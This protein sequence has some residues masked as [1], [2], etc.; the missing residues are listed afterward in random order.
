MYC[1]YIL[2]A[3]GA[4]IGLFFALRN[5]SEKVK[6]IV[7]LSIAFANLAQH[8]FKPFIYPH[9]WGN[10]SPHLSSAYNVCAF[11]ILVTPFVLLFG[12]ELL[13]NYMTYLG[14]IAGMIAMLVPY[15]FIGKSAFQWEA[16]RFYLCHTLL[17]ISSILPALLGFHK[18]RWRHFWKMGLLFLAMLAI[19]LLNDAFFVSIGC[20]DGT[21]PDDVYGSLCLINPCW[22]VLPPE[23]FDWLVSIIAFFSPSFLMGGNSAGFYVPVL[24]YAIPMYLGI[25][26]AAFVVCAIIDTS[27]FKHDFSMLK[28]LVKRI[29]KK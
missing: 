12:N 24:W 9:Y 18:M 22:S 13:R 7:L 14:T 4:C 23:N 3:V 5:K 17:F 28:Q 19:I 8:I 10:F 26:L 16:Y 11:L 21:I 25:T 15:W 6:R 29:C 20:Y 1:V 27:S 2:I